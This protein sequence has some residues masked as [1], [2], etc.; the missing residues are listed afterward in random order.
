[1]AVKRW[2]T[3]VF[4]LSAFTGA[5]A[6]TINAASCSAS[7][8]QKA[9]SSVTSSTTTV[10]I[11]A[12][13]G[14]SWTN[15]VTLT[16]PS[17]SSTFSVIGAGSQSTT[18]G[19]DATVIIDNYASSNP[20]LVINTAGSSSV[21]RISGISVEA[22]S[23]TT[24]YNGIV[25]I[26]GAS[27]NVR[28]DHSHFSSTSSS[29]VQFIG[30]ING[31]VDHSIFDGGGVSN[32]V[33]AYNAGSCYNDS[34]GVGDQSWAHST[35]LGSSNFLFM[36]NNVFNSG[37][38][39]DCTDG[40]R[41]V[42]RFNTFNTTTPAPTVQTHPTGG[43]QRE[44]GCRAWEVYK[45]Q[46]DAVSGNYINA[47]FFVSSGTGVIWGNTAPSSSAG[48]GTGYQNFITGHVMRA[49]NNTYPQS[50]PPNGWGYCGTAQTGSP[51]EWDQNTSSTGYACLDQVGRGV[52]QLLV[53]DFPNM[54]NNSTGNITWPKQAL[55]PVYEWLDAWT[56]V[57]NN[58]GA[59]WGEYESQ[60]QQNRDY[61]LGTSN[62]GGQISFNGT[63]GVGNGTLA[64]RPSTCTKGVAYWATDQGN[65]N[66]SGSGGQGELYACT[67]TNTWTL[68]YSPYTY[69]HPL[70]SGSPSTP[71]AA[72]SA[73]TALQGVVH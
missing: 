46:F 50:A 56:P 1:M 66:Q 51:S 53:N 25:S 73:P 45:N 6:Q 62:S 54:T 28:L 22:G 36:E 64:A 14:T 31:V 13:N 18:G 33:R 35:S 26:G 38:S 65:W 34:L 70:V 43:G 37:A 11:P 40:G 9:F 19:G 49:N 57:P 42:S 47:G 15:Q 10:S 67:A 41:F 17:S 29:M 72:P 39:N 61:Y 52:G 12:C 27:Q 2:I 16:V 58:P 23:G 69:P 60:A 55:E 30:C 32:A 63:S 48:G 71:S 3:L 20:L 59:V 21:L 24:K 44:R 8:V 7:D 4:L 68:Y 5:K